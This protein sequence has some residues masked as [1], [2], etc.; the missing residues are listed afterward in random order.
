V[1]YAIGTRDELNGMVA[2]VEKLDRRC[3]ALEADV[4]D[5]ARM[6]EGV[7]Q[8]VAELGGLGTVVIK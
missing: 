8:N 5:S 6:R 3:L 4:R 2:E 7:E 1:P